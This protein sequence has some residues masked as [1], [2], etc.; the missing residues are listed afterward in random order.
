MRDKRYLP[1]SKVWARY[2]V[3]QDEKTV[4]DPHAWQSLAN[5]KIYVANIRDALVQ[6]A[7]L[8]T[9]PMRRNSSMASP[10]WTRR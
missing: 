4:T 8:P 5:G 9:R 2:G 6:K 7:R 3:T 1:D 10:P